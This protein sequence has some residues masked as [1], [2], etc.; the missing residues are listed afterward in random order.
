MLDRIE[1][2]EALRSMALKNIKRF[3]I[4]FFVSEFDVDIKDAARALFEFS[5]NSDKLHIKYELRC[6]NCIEII[7]EFEHLEDIKKGQEIECE[8]CGFEN[9]ID[10]DNI[11]IVYYIDDEYRNKIRNVSK[12][13]KLSRRHRRK[14]VCNKPSSSIKLLDEQGAIKLSESESGYNINY[15]CVT[16]NTNNYENNGLVGAMGHECKANDF[17]F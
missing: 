4:E 6:S 2:E 14:P 17:K 3:Y 15:F 1:V 5:R 8:D 16:V 7:D 10:S 9:I 13:D 12:K 11:Y